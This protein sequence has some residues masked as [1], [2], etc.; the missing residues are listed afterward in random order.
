M[1]SNCFPFLSF[2]SH[3]TGAVSRLINL[4]DGGGEPSTQPFQPFF[5][6]T[7][8]LGIRLI[9]RSGGDDG[10]AWMA[11]PS[12]GVRR[13]LDDVH[14]VL[15]EMD[16]PGVGG[17][18]ERSGG[19]EGDTERVM[20]AMGPR[21]RQKDD[22]LL[23]TVGVPRPGVLRALAL[24]AIDNFVDGPA[25]DTTVD[26]SLRAAISARLRSLFSRL[27]IRRVASSFSTIL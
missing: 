22:V 15:D 6:A 14:D 11:S 21:A 23:F 25:T 18:D 9:G 10:P 8:F 16:G 12:S 7:R 27:F 17:G 26:L 5:A 2:L 1:A 19:G 3:I 24:L 13:R 4:S 20:V